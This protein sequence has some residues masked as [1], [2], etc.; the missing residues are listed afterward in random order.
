MFSLLGSKPVS[1][2][3]F[4][5][6]GN[7]WHTDIVKQLKL[8]VTDLSAKYGDLP[9]LSQVN[10]D[11][12]VVFTWNGTTSGVRVPNGDWIPADRKGLTLCDATSAV[13]AQHMDW[14]KLDVVT[15]S[16]QKCLGG[17]GGHG[18]LVLSPRAVERLETVKSSFPLP[19]IFRLTKAGKLIKGVFK[20]SPINTPSMLC[21]EDQIDALTWAT[22]EG[23]YPALIARAN[24][25]LSEIERFVAQTPW[26]SFLSQRPECR[27]NTSVCLLINDM[28]A[29]Q[30]KQM[31]K[32]LDRHAIAYDIGS[33][34]DAPAGLR[35]WCGPTVEQ[36]DVANLMS[37][38]AWAHDQVK[39]G[40]IQSMNIVVVDGMQASGVK[41]LQAAGHTVTKK[42]ISKED[43]LAGALSEFDAIILRSATK[44]PAAV[45]N[46]TAAVAGSKLKVIARAGVGVDNID[47]NAATAAG[48]PVLNAPFSAT[49]SVVE[50]ALGHLLASARHIAR[51]TADIKAGVW[52]KK[53]CTGHELR[54][55]NLGFVGF[56]RIGQALATV[57]R[58]LGMNIF[59]YDPY[60]P[61]AV[62][63][64]LCAS[65]GATRKATLPDLFR[66]CTHVT[67]HAML[68]KETRHM[69]NYDLVSLM[70]GVAPDGTKCG[71]HLI[72]CARG[73]VVDEESIAAALKDNT[74]KSLALDVFEEEPLK[75]S[76]LKQYPQFSATP[77]IGAST[78]EAQNRVGAEI[79][80]AVIAFFDNDI[81]MGNVVNKAVYK[82]ASKL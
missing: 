8:P 77:H 68:T 25:N 44:L 66:N 78:V 6:F 51:A 70:P 72:S 28:E 29:Q 2:A 39:T 42:K 21:I 10:W 15:Y 30:V 13:F 17:E 79:A 37:W 40:S 48:V 35:I 49:H 33:Y 3:R 38:V 34:R 9:D 5:S 27:S 74:L 18:M 63:D 7:G 55:K 1:V 75:E 57:A 43:L 62:S 54:G 76:S 59:F 46:A 52:S 60:L 50:L 80:S 47:L 81:P 53:A 58:A 56:G 12:D 61:A 69:I 45:L 20:D 41:M 36:A 67:V 31:T 4:E 82:P 11:G 71:N 64:K 73:G 32:L 14:S 65:M 24:A 23:G 16:W 22:A 19:K 26:I